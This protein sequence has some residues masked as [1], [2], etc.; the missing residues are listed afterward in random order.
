M[1]V[2][3]IVERIEKAAA[4]K[5]S[6]KYQQLRRGRR[7]IRV[8]NLVKKAEPK[9][10]TTKQLREWAGQL[11]KA[12]GPIFK[13]ASLPGQD[14][15]LPVMGGTKFPTGD[16][17]SGAK[18]L[19]TKSMGSA[20]VGPTP[21]FGRL[22]PPGPK[23]HE[24]APTV[25]GAQNLMPKVGSDMNIENDPLV[26]Y[27][28]KQAEDI[29]KKVT[30]EQGGTISN[31]VADMPTGPG[32]KELTSDPPQPEGEHVD[33]SQDHTSSKLKELLDHPQSRK[34]YVDKDH[35]PKAGAVDRILAAK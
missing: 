7:P 28:K 11:R 19:L 22:S 26:Q 33:R 9:I 4:S 29:P 14:L 30:T 5:K 25:P 24:D 21:K 6:V 32:E 27:L 35:P 16:S 18:S 1:S 3:Q 23:I 13:K 34:K 15:R 10:L 20:E 17:L 2:K 12:K 8:E 31:N